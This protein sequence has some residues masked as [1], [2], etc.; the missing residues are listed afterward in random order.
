MVFVYSSSI[1]EV[2]RSSVGSMSRAPD[3]GGSSDSVYYCPCKLSASRLH[4]TYAA[5]QEL[6]LFQST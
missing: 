1:A 2:S 6:A 4:P 3:L 5:G